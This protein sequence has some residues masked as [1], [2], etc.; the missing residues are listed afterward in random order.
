MKQHGHG[1]TKFHRGQCKII[2]I[3]SRRLPRRIKDTYNIVVKEPDLNQDQ[4]C[5]HL[6]APQSYDSD[7]VYRMTSIKYQSKSS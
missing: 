2:D 7:E 4:V 1:F 6:Q 5:H 3:D